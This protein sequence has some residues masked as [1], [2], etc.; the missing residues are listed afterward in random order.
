MPRKSD[1]KSKYFVPSPVISAFEMELKRTQ[2][3][4]F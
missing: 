4:L 2:M 1:R 3:L